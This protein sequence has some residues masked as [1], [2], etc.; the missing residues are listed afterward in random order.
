MKA[1]PSG[2]DKYERIRKLGQG[3][4]VNHNIYHNNIYYHKY[5]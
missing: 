3:M 2:Q 5:M 1:N 4:N